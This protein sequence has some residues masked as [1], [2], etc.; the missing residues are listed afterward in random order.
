MMTIK[1]RRERVEKRFRALPRELQKNVA[2]AVEKGA[3]DVAGQARRFAP[4]DTGDLRDSITVTGPGGT[5]PPYSQPGGSQTMGPMQSMVTA[6]NKD[7]RY[8]HLPEYGTTTMKA[9]PYFWPAY[10]LHK[11][12]IVRRIKTAVGKALRRDAGL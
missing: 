11:K 6:G 3:D 8:A 2:D 1:V 12:R 4:V 7:V 10:R 9:Q 5:T